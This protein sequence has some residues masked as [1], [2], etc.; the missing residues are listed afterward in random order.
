MKLRKLT[1]FVE[2]K[3]FILKKLYNSK[4]S[5]SNSDMLHVTFPLQWLGGY[6]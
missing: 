5:C 4:I 1:W 3:F 2:Y 6:P